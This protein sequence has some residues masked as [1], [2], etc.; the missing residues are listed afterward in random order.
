MDLADCIVKSILQEIA[1]KSSFFAVPYFILCVTSLG[2]TEIVGLLRL[3]FWLKW[4]FLIRVEI[5]LNFSFPKSEHNSKLLQLLQSKPL[6]A[7]RQ[8]LGSYYL[9]KFIDKQ[10]KQTL[11][12]YFYLS[13]TLQNR[14]PFI[15]KRVYHTL[16][17]VPAT[18][19]SNLPQTIPFYASYQ[20]RHF[21]TSQEQ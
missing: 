18:L 10:T 21:L 1:C 6:L 4:K 8:F 17:P 2:K 15:F 12:F 5:K 14:I 19:Q 7:L 11:P 16:Y 9:Y 20:D 13:C 3:A